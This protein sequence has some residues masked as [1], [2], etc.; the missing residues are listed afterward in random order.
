MFVAIKKNSCINVNSKKSATPD[1]LYYIIF[2]QI[3]KWN[4][5]SKMWVRKLDFDRQLLRK[6]ETHAHMAIQVDSLL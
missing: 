4:I 3:G 1:S 5:M 2:Y 6:L